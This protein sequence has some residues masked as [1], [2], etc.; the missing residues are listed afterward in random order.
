MRSFLLSV[1][2]IGCAA[3]ISAQTLLPV[4]H[5]KLSTKQS[6]CEL[7]TLST[8]VKVVGKKSLAKGVTMQV[9]EN[10]EGITFKRIVSN[11][12]NS[13]NPRLKK[14]L[15]AQSTSSAIALSEGFEG[16]DGTDTWQPEGWATESKGTPIESD[17]IEA[18][19]V[20]TAMQYAPEPIG[21]YYNVIY[22]SVE[23]KEEWL[24]SPQVTLTEHPMLYYHAYVS[25][26]FLFNLN[27]VDW[28][29]YEFTS[30]EP[31]ANLQILIKAEGDAEWTVIKDYYEEYKDYTLQEL[32][33]IEDPSNLE[34]FSIDLSAWASKK[35]Q[36]AF[37]YFGTD[38]NTMMVDN[39]TLSEP[40]LEAKYSYPLGTLF[41]GMSKDWSAMTLSLPMLPVGEE[42]YWYN[43]S[44][45]YDVD[46]EWQYHDWATNDIATTNTTDLAATYYP[47]YTS[48]FTCRNNTYDSP[49]LTISKEGAAPGEFSRYS[50]F[51]AG[52]RAEWKISGDIKVFGMLPF[53]INT[54][55]FDIAV[56]D[57]DMK[58]AIPI[59]GYSED[60]DAFW[61][62]YTFQ[63]QEEEGEGV[64]LTGIFNYYYTMAQ[65]LVIS[66]AWI[67]A[68]GQ[69][70]ENAL[71]TL[72]IIPLDD[73]GVMLDPI[74]TAT[75]KGSD[76]T[77]E[78]GGSQ[79]FYTIPFKF[80]TPVV[81]SQDV[82]FSYIIRLSGFNDPENVTYF[83]PYQS[84]QDHP[85]GY[86]LGWIE[87]MITMNGETRSSLSPMAYYSGYQTFAINLDAAYPWLDAE[88][89][90]VNID[91]T[92]MAEV[93]LGSY[94]DGAELTATQ[95]DGSALPEW[96][97]AT[98]SGRYNNAKV[99]FTASADKAATCDVK[100]AG[101]GVSQIITV[102]TGSSSL[103]SIANDEAE[104]VNV[105]NVSGQQISGD[106]PAGLYIVRDS[107]GK[108]SKKIVK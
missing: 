15:K 12:Q 77:M 5:Q 29:A 28:D 30:K 81:M 9:V 44:E 59:Y 58:P 53:D 26:L 31:A 54:E 27:N 60:V 20:S 55:G 84:S 86:A 57:N 66:E 95:A 7:K 52:G 37:R 4:E 83:A 65:P 102:N 79:N 24:I 104:V 51:Q 38:G 72:D 49:K 82:C 11:R 107:N 19:L 17:H 92:G 32:F 25:P 68:K 1:L 39:V 73:E 76:M 23:E 105:F 62:N 75:C 34:K 99:E 13:I 6:A 18:W 2:A 36:I 69:I 96:L 3:T 10:Q 22:Y 80:N 74:A 91:A 35:A 103:N 85:D 64:K 100:I 40:S 78:E 106:L 98:I 67:P 16:Y 71:F 47:D 93:A 21:S 56:V 108:V 48:E 87:K 14:S 97:N 8:D 45:D 41:Y 46:C 90:E 43:T 42:L 94:Y 89:N 61:T 70:G 33:S 101:P 50:Y 88:K 63:G